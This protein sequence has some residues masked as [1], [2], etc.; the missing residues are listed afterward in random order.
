MLNTGS[1]NSGAAGLLL[2]PS[3]S[4]VEVNLNNT[5]VRVSGGS[6]TSGVILQGSVHAFINNGSSISVF[7]QTGSIYGVRMLNS[8]IATIN[9]SPISVQGSGMPIGIQ[10]E[11]DSIVTTDG[12]DL[13]V[14]A[15]NNQA[16]GLVTTQN[17]DIEYNGQFSHI[18]VSGNPTSAIGFA[19]GGPIVIGNTACTLN[20]AEVIC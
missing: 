5:R 13:F 8:S 16:I 3:S 17:G 12:V 1:T 19:T 7:G 10:A 14:G 18:T 2:F 6:N 11:G 20:G 4:G 9:A 15:N